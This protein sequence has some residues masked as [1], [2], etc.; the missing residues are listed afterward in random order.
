MTHLC[1]PSCQLR[2][3]P[4]AAAYL[5][6][7]PKCRQALQPITDLSRGVGFSLFTPEDLPPVL[8]EAVAVSIPVPDPDMGRS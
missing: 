2:F 3:K 6:A 4:A 1:C 7:C 8:P 5:A